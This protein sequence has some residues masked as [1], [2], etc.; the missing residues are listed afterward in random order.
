MPTTV[1]QNGR[2]KWA[3]VG[4]LWLVSFCNYAD[5]SALSGVMPQVRVWFGLT[6][7]QLGML[8]TCFLWVYAGSAALLGYLGDRFS[9]KIVILTG[10]VFWS[11]MCV[12]TPLASSFIAL[13]IIRG[14]TGF[15][16]ASYYPAGTALIS[17]FHDGRTRSRALSI[18]QTAVFVGGTAGT[19][20]AAMLAERYDWRNAYY[21]Y[22]GFGIFLALAMLFGLRDT[23]T[24][25]KEDMPLGSA[26]RGAVTPKG[27]DSS[28][29]TVSLLILS[30]LFIGAN[31]VTYALTT[32]LPTYFYEGM[33]LSLTR[34]AFY[35]STALN[36]AT[37][38]GVLPGGVLGDWTMNKTIVG[39]CYLLAGSLTVA[40]AFLILL[41]K[42]HSVNLAACCLIGAGFFKGLFDA[43]IYAA[44]HDVTPAPRRATAVGMLTTI[45]FMGAALGPM[46]IGLATNHYGLRLALSST[47]VVYL[48]CAAFT[49]LNKRI[50]ISDMTARSSTLRTQDCPSR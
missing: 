50:L 29:L 27:R 40:A 43:N 15:G 5:R 30:V 44:V 17:E 3:V 25:T 13:L 7:P 39:R 12:L 34:S 45:G 10:L 41:G 42:S 31:F 4:M 38:A 33:H 47:S 2:Y 6:N 26:G 37:L 46:L 16:E 18:H 20:I 1:N 48:A 21:A 49:F 19:T 24:L 35:G 11:I 8:T 36:M 9:R 32:W 23:V 28:L 22:G 14:L